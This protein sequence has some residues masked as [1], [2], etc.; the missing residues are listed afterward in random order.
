MSRCN[1]NE[2]T[3]TLW[4]ARTLN[5]RAKPCIKSFSSMHVWQLTSRSWALSR[6]QVLPEY[7]W[8][9]KWWT[10]E[11]YTLYFNHNM[12]IINL[13]SY[14]QVSSF[15]TSENNS[16]HTPSFHSFPQ[17]CCSWGYNGGQAHQQQLTCWSWLQLWPVCAALT[18]SKWVKFP[19]TDVCLKLMLVRQDTGSNGDFGETQNKVLRSDGKNKGGSIR[20]SRIT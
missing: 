2:V 1:S 3:N 15:Q 18:T 16:F 7:K 10:R 20:T 14:Y 11:P 19:G 9:I 5:H 17:N 13:Y 4:P 8:N 6:S 12:A